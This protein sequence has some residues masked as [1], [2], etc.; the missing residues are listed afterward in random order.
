MIHKH[1]PVRICVATGWLVMSN[2]TEHRI[3]TDPKLSM[4]VS[5]AKLLCM[6]VLLNWLVGIWAQKY[7]LLKM[8]N[9]LTV[10]FLLTIWNEMHQCSCPQ[11]HILT[12]FSYS[13]SWQA[14]IFPFN[15]GKICQNLCKS[16]Q[17]LNLQWNTLWP[18]T[19]RDGREQG[20]LSC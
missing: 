20:R 6:K 14:R 9:A 12:F 11:N 16:F 1:W 7:L 8:C 4:S 19:H 2:Y 13:A 3:Q 18:T 5:L 10:W 15:W 17:R